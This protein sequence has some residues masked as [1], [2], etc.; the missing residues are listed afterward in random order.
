MHD[1]QHEA[2]AIRATIRHLA[3]GAGDPAPVLAE[4]RRQVARLAER[5]QTLR[6]PLLRLLDELGDGPG[7]AA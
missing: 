1:S 5:D 6:G 4:L 7:T 2:S 3:E